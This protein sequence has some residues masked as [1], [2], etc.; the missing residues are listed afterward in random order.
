MCKEA[1]MR[2]K[3]N[4]MKRYV[5]ILLA[6][7][8]GLLFV[9]RLGMDKGIL[10]A[11]II[12]IVE[13]V[14]LFW[15]LDRFDTLSQEEAAGIEKTA[16]ASTAQAFLFAES[17]MLM[18]DDDHIITW[19]SELFQKRGLNRVGDKLLAWLPE[20]EPLINGSTDQVSVQLDDRIYAISRKEDEPVL[21]FKD[22]TELEQTRTAFNEGR[23]VI[24]MAS[25]DNYIEATEFEEDN[26]AASISQA[27]RTPINDYCKDHGILVKR[28][29][30]DRYFL[31]LNE[32][33]FSDLAADHFSILATVRKAAQKQDVSITLS[34]AFARGFSS[35]EE[36]DDTVNR[37]M[38]LVQSRGGDQVAVQEAG[39]EVVYFG[40]SVEATEKR[41]RVRVRVMAHTLRELLSRSSNVIICGHRSMDFDCMG[42]AL[43]AA[44]IAQALHKQ[45]VIISRTGGI[46]E[47]LNA[48]LEEK[49]AELEEEVRF[50]TENEA[51]NQLG[52][53][54]LVVLVDHNNISQSNGAKVI[55]NASQIVVIDHH[56]RSS[57]MGFKPTLVYIEAGASSASELIVELIPYISNR[58]EIPELDASIMLAGITVDTGRFH[59]RTGVRTFDASSTLRRWGADPQVVDGWLKD[60]FAET[61]Q[62]ARA[63]SMSQDIGRG[64]ILVPVRNEVLSR[65]MMSQIADTVLEIQ[66]VEAVFVIADDT[67]QETA[68]SARSSGRINVQRIMERMNG[69]GHLTAAAMQR[70]RC[71]MDGLV[72]ELKQAIDAYFEEEN[73]ESHS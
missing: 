36:S 16:G 46:E 9:F 51:M 52:P 65:S 59:M 10:S 66:N 43:G 64:I 15:A 44:H 69:G 26:V 14:V 1:A 13:A 19:M 48:V 73:N 42:S 37:L 20:A 7:Q 49:S 11:T 18:Y 68:I 55:A 8:V 47:K 2:Q 57:E 54:T 56:R 27:V 3:I 61:A 12:L 38:D 62:K 21:F 72:E 58:I 31:L 35:Y 63:L 22:V 41:S 5:L 60:S 25:L 53:R 17:G 67:Q 71:E 39:E 50:V 6:V 30:N 4:D 45:A 70:P 34:L 32:K 23:T 28:V 29:S 40:G 33:I 24:G